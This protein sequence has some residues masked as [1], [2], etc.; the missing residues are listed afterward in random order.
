MTQ[1]IDADLDEVQIPTAVR[2]SGGLHTFSG[3]IAFL[4]GLQ[5][6][7]TLTYG[8][9]AGVEAFVPYLLILSGLSALLLGTFV[10]RGRATAALVATGIAGLHFVGGG[11]YFILLLTWGVVSLIALIL[12]MIAL[13]AVVLGG[14]MLPK[15]RKISAARQR[16][17]DS[18]LDFG[19]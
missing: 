2:M 4:T 16:L 6:S 1:A 13:G 3:L 11:V 10:Y 15:I 7:I 19:V 17:A 8:R 9:G 18:G 5:L 12:P 14:Y